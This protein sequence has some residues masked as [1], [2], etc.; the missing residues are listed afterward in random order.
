[1]DRLQ[2]GTVAL[3]AED[4]RNLPAEGATADESDPMLWVK[5]FDCYS[6]GWTWYASEYDPASRIFFGYVEG[7]ENEWGSFALDDFLAPIRGHV[8]LGIERDLY[9]TPCRF[10]ELGR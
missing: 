9:F 7:F 8:G 1:M 5:F 10:S 3:T 2:N 4:L 6:N